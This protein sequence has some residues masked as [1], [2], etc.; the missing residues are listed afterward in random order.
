MRTVEFTVFGMPKP[1][2]STRSFA[3]RVKGRFR[4][5]GEPLY[6]AVTTT[7]NPGLKSWESVVRF[8]AQ[9][10]MRADPRVFDGAVKFAAVFHLPRP[11]SVSLKKRPFPIVKPDCD[12]L[13]RAAIDP[14]TGVLFKD[15][16]QV[17]RIE[18]TKLYT[19]GP[20]KAVITVSDF[21]PEGHAHA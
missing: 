2:G 4:R 1:K 19:D 5:N 18:T 7:D 13:T 15:D 8:E 11:G 9:R 12:K 17:C 16:A 20:A 3:M 21:F 14:L 6:R 10:V